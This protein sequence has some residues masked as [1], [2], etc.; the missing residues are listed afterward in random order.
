MKHSI[1]ILLSIALLAA[2]SPKVD[3]SKVPAAGPAP[4]IQIGD[5]QQ[6][7]LANGLK[8]IVVENH[9]LPRVS[10]N[11]TLDTDPVLE[12]NKSGYVSMAGDLLAAGTTT[13]TKAQIDESIDYIGASL[14]TS[15]QGI[16]GSCLK[17]HSDRFLEVMSD[18]LLHPSFAQNE[19][20]KSIKQSLSGLASTKTDPNSISENIGATANYGKDHPYGELMTESTVKNIT[21]DD[22]LSYYQSNFKPG[23][24]Y[25]VIVGDITF[26][27]AKAQAE[28]Y[29]G[30]WK[31]GQAMEKNYKKP[32]APAGN[33][34]IFSP[35]PGAVQSVIDITYPVD[36]QPGTQD[37]I[38]AGVLNNILGGSGFQARLMQNLRED[39]AY[40]YGAYSSI[41]PDEI[42]GSFSAG[43]S[44]R[45]EVTDSSI[46]EFLYEMEKLVNEPVADSTMQTIKNI[47]TGNFARSLERP[48]TI[49][50]FALNI[51]KY[52]LP[53]DFYK[54]YLQ[55][56]NAVTA[57]DVQ[58]MAKRVIKPSNCNITV[59][60]NKEIEPKLARF[61]ANGKVEVLNF[62]GTPF[63]AMKPAP[64]GI[65]VQDVLNNHIKAMGGAEALSKVKSYEQNG[66]LAMGPMSMGVNIKMKDN[67]KFKM[68]ITMQGMEA[69]KNVYDGTKGNMYQ[70]GQK[71]VMEDGDLLDSKMQSDMLGEMHYAQYGIVP[72][73]IGIENVDGQDA[74]AV[75]LKKGDEEL[76]TDYFSVATGLRIKS[77]TMEGEGAEAYTVESSFTEYGQQE[78]IKFVKKMIVNQGGQVMEFNYTEMKINPKIEDKEFVVE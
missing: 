67:S 16:S 25:L 3:R 62:D 40:T 1:Y 27:E 4:I 34:V 66:T 55:K 57:A 77:V 63:M 74:Y 44:V 54:T 42:I 31:G 14:G 48:Q 43:A 72:T 35:I 26:A 29:F 49:A 53:K 56:L 11:I 39:K 71:S 68:L 50:N 12:G 41:S 36:L 28:K 59:V 38:V 5:A 47:M 13:R 51:E 33:R 15:S 58:A 52:N 18:V 70:M 78:G 19:F 32:T 20:E 60:G 64:A 24:A 45:N 23:S 75:Q 22:L 69:M 30:L 17:K 46:V 61:A 2:C 6:I 10:Y 21:R 73:L 37:A 76:S 65:T 8:V 7:Q 9:K